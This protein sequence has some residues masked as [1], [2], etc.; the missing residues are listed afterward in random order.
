MLRRDLLALTGLMVGAGPS[1]WAAGS[2]AALPAATS[3]ALAP[4]ALW[5]GELQLQ[6]DAT[7]LS[8]RLLRAELTVPVAHLTAQAGQTLRLAYPRFLPGAHGPYGDV[9]RLAGLRCRTEAGPLAWQRDALD[10]HVFQVQLPAGAQQLQLSFQYL[11]PVQPG[12]ERLSITRQMLG[13]EWE[14]VL[15]LPADW[16]VAALPV[17]TRLRLPPGWTALTALRAPTGELASAD[18]QGLHTFATT[19]AEALIDAP[20]FAG[21]H[22]R[23]I[24]LDA[25][26]TPRAVWLNLVADHPKAL[27]ASAVQLD[28][29]R[30]LVKQADALFGGERPWRHYD[31]LLALSDEFGG[32]GLEHQESSEN[33]LAPDYFDEWDAAIRGR[34]LLPHEFVHAWNGKAQRPADLWVPHY[35]TPMGTSLLWVYEGLTQYWGHVLAARAGLTTAEQARDRL[36]WTLAEWQARSGRAWRSLQDTTAEPRLG[37]GHTAEWEDWQRTADYYDEGQLLWLEVDLLLRRQGR[38]GVSLDDVGRAFFGRPA[39]RD[40]AGRVLP[41]TYQLDDVVAALQ[42]LLPI[43]W[44]AFFRERLD[45][46][47]LA[48]AAPQVLANAGWRLVWHAEESRFAQHERGWSGPNGNERPQDLAHSLGLRVA[49]DGKLVNVMWDSPAWRAELAPGMVLLAVNGR[50]YKPDRLA[51]AVAD[52]EASRSAPTP[53]RLWLKDGDRY[54]EAMPAVTS[55][56][57]YPALERVAAQSDL[58]SGVYAARAPG[59]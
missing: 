2:A 16:P 8:R 42:R 23:R 53:L 10:T 20:L 48:A 18:A 25:P 9:S 45:R 59:A 12:G 34:E 57:R 44:Q 5:P 31:F 50:G 6:V 43:D 22:T 11:A 47:N 58:L 27:Q 15:L 1:A 39:P 55:G 51:Q 36:A 14:T 28:A 32:I 17:R 4:T 21:L 13:I 37:P 41:M 30:A 3:S 35:N 52:M 46:T 49:S 26:G 56:L 29:H 33:A 40:A 7:D 54:F 38:G 24:A 19:T